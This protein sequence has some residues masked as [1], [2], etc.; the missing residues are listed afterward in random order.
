MDLTA[1]LWAGYSGFDR[2]IVGGL[3]VLLCQGPLMRSVRDGPGEDRERRGG[4]RRTSGVSE[5]E[6]I[7]R[8]L[9]ERE[10]GGSERERERASGGG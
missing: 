1:T 10:R 6:G 8:W 4:G 7:R 2:Y 5:R 9:R 3:R